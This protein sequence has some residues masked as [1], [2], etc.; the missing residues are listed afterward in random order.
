ML[1]KTMIGATEAKRA[2]DAAIDAAEADGQPM[3][4]AVADSYGEIVAAARM[5]GSPARVLRHAIRQAYTSG[6]MHRNT[7]KFK[8]QLR[9]RDGKLDEWGDDML[10]TLPGGV[11]I[12]FGDEVIGA[13]GAGGG[14]ALPRDTEIAHLAVAAIGEGITSRRDSDI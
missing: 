9:E 8:Q 4:F 13:I 12:Y 11:A 5:D 6:S 14:K 2:L 3:S 1:T 10:T 7:I